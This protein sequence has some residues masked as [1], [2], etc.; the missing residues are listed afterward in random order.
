MQTDSKM[1]ENDHKTYIAI[2]QQSLTKHTNRPSKE[3]FDHLTSV[4]LYVP[5]LISVTNG[6]ANMAPPNAIAPSFQAFSR[7]LVRA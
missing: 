2:V 4:V 6:A 1:M 3:Q 5:L 7:S